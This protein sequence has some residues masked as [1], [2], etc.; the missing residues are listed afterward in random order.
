MH[1]R[2]DTPQQLIL[3]SPG[4]QSFSDDGLAANRPHLHAVNLK[5]PVL[6]AAAARAL[7]ADEIDCNS[8][9]PT[10]N[11]RIADHANQGR[12]Q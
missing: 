5:T 6:R 3:F 2:I 10:D 7:R 11:Q 8:R 9:L 1:D 12:I 4:I